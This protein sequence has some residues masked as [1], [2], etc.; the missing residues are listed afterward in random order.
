M[1]R[2]L[3]CVTWARIRHVDSAPRSHGSSNG[4]AVVGQQDGRWDVS[5]PWRWLHL[6]RRSTCWQLRPECSRRG[7]RSSLER[8]S[9][10]SERP[11]SGLRTLF[12]GQARYPGSTSTNHAF[13]VLS[14]SAQSTV[15]AQCSGSLSASDKLRNCPRA[16]SAAHWPPF[17]VDQCT[18]PSKTKSSHWPLT[19][20]SSL[21]MWRFMPSRR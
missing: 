8:R 4:L 5:H 2:T 10:S 14:T 9:A 7:R 13:S 21:Y 6:L 15:R 16:T 11:L 17:H 3:S 1:P 19:S 12:V 20:A 18:I